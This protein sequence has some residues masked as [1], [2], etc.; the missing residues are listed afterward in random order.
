MDEGTQPLRLLF[1]LHDAERVAELPDKAA[2]PW[3]SSGGIKVALHGSSGKR[4]LTRVGFR[5]LT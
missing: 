4:D 3:L 1:S 5:S 2:N